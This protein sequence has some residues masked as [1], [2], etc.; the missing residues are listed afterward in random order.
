MK[1]FIEGVVSNQTVLA[2]AI[3]ELRLEVEALKAC[4]DSND[5]KGGN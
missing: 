4:R 5:T 2:N 3:D 1:E